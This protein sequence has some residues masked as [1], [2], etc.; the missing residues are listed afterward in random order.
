[1]AQ[2]TC[3]LVRGSSVFFAG[4]MLAEISGSDE[5]RGSAPS[6]S[7]ERNSKRVFVGNDKKVKAEAGARVSRQ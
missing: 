5:H 2:R 4:A 1:M 6:N 7:Q 3:F